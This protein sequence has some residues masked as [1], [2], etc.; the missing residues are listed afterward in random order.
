VIVEYRPPSRVAAEPRRADGL[1]PLVFRTIQVY[2]KDLRRFLGIL[3]L[4]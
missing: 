2:P 4:R 3:T 1:G